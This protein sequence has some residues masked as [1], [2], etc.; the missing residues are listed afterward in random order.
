MINSQGSF[1]HQFN[2]IGIFY[3]WSGY[4]DQND[5]ISFRGV[6]QVDAVKD[7]EFNVGVVL[8]GFNGT[9]LS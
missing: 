9:C 8:N 2:T 1:V 5:Q 3:Y 4:V 7:R 6:V